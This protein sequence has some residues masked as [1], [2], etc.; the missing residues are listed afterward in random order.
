L[1]GHNQ[2]RARL[3]LKP[4]IWSDD[5]AESARSWAQSLLARGVFFHKPNNPYGENLFFVDGRLYE[6]EEVVQRWSSEAVDYDRST[7]TC[8]TVCG[9][10]T[11]IVWRDTRRV[12]CAAVNVDLRQIWVCEYD[13]P[14]N[15]IGERPY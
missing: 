15:Y 8:S 1:L 14:G 13:P 2:I 10:Y 4:L 12:G 9:H 3:G 6:G 5:L 11:Q 7:N